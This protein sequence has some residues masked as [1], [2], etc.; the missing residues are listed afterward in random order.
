MRITG[1][2]MQGLVIALLAG[3]AV[4]AG[5]TAGMANE[6][7]GP[8]LARL[9]A[10]A[11]PIAAAPD[12]RAR[13]HALLEFIDAALDLRMLAERLV[14]QPWREASPELQARFLAALRS[15]LARD[16]AGRTAE[17]AGARWT[18]QAV[19]GRDSRLL[20]IELL[21]QYEAGSTTLRYRLFLDGQ[22]W[23]GY[24]VV[25]RGHSLL[26]HYRRLFSRVLRNGGLALLVDELEARDNNA[27][28]GASQPP[29]AV[30]GLSGAASGGTP[31]SR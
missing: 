16:A 6:P 21:G 10:L 29:G 5:L 8:I 13:H 23:R 18:V 25:E 11:P 26:A 30:S 28:E 9:E 7:A 20:R 15:Q 31:P 3:S 4:A 1:R 27:G 22:A 19:D 2:L 17:L 12:A 14:G 24:D